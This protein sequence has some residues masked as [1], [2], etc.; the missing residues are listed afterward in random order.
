MSWFSNLFKQSGQDLPSPSD[1]VSKESIP[2]LF[3]LFTAFVTQAKLNIPFTKTPI[4][5]MPGV[6]SKSL[7]P[8]M[9][10]GTNNIFIAGA[11]EANQKIMVDFIKVGDM[12]VYRFPADMTKPTT[13]FIEHRIVE[14]GKDKLGRYFRFK[15]DNNSSRDPY[16]V[17]SENIKWLSIGVIY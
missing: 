8:V 4:V 5:W 1:I 6:A 10:V 11:D 14:I 7:D 2:L 17:K 9:D 13:T 15:G 12:A 16:K 3:T